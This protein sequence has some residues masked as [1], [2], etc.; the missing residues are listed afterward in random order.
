MCAPRY[1]EY[2]STKVELHRFRSD[3]RCSVLIFHKFSN[4][5][6]DNLEKIVHLLQRFVKQFSCRHHLQYD[7]VTQN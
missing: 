5:D 6:D 3:R 2:K 7:D 1:A 4:V